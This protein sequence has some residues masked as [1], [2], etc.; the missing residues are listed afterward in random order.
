[1]PL[2]LLFSK[3][4]RFGTSAFLAS[5]AISDLVTIFFAIPSHLVSF[6]STT[7][8]LLGNFNVGLF[9]CKIVTYMEGKCV[10]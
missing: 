1:M 7:W 4:I 5:L 8:N 2:F 6:L 9:A 10:F 3:D